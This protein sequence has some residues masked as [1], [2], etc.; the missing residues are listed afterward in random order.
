MNKK[1]LFK[2]LLIPAIAL[3]AFGGHLFYKTYTKYSQPPVS[4]IIASDTHYLSHDYRGDYFKEP[5]GM[6]DGK[7]I[8]YSSDYFDAFL[9]EV[10][11]KAPDVLILSGDITL[12]G[13]MKS[14]EEVTQKLQKVEE[15]GID[16]L[17]IPGN[18]DVRTTAGDYTPEEPIVV[19]SALAGGFAELYK[20][21]GPDL[22]LSQDSVS[23]SYIYEASPYLRIL[24]IDTN[25]LSKGTVHADTLKWIEQELKNA[26]D[27]D[28]NVIA[29][30]HQNLHIHNELLYF[31][32]QLYNADEL[33]AL[34]ETY[35][36]ALNLSGHIHIQ[37]IVDNGTVPEVAVGSLAIGGT[38]YGEI[39][40]TP[41]ELTYTT[42]KT[43]V[44]AYAASV[45]LTDENLLDFNNY[46]MWYFEEVGRLQSYA[47]L[48]ESDLS[49]DEKVL[50]ADTFAEVNALYFLGETY[51]PSIYSNGIELWKTQTGDFT[52]RYI[53]TMI[54]AAQE[55]N[56]NITIQLK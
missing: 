48:A 41:Q 9:A 20:N 45:G 1:N 25:T 39:T 23:L 7:V 34:F 14:H 40:Y 51:D 52:Y 54:K 19:E 50:L 22:A 42:V 28:A 49:E 37:S 44:S 24:M 18:H 21:F 27:A 8:H 30:T 3:I 16:V 38:P 36:V 11:E 33:L 46:S 47:G 32:Y 10:I 31:T 13:S 5:S 4:I 26:Q 12:N 15:A 35:D 29:V 55:D 56:Q 2:V 17:V 53:E 6:F 43:D